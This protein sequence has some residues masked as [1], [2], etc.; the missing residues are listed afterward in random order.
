MKDNINIELSRELKTPFNEFF[1]QWIKGL[2]NIDTFAISIILP[3]KKIM[4]LSTQEIFSNTYRAKNLARYDQ[5]TQA[6]MYE[7]HEYYSWRRTGCNLL[8][9]QIHNFREHQFKMYNGTNFVRKAE[10]DEGVFYIIYSI[11]SH[12]KKPSNYVDFIANH[13]LIIQASDFFY[14][15]ML[16]HWQSFCTQFTLPSSLNTPSIQNQLNHHNDCLDSVRKKNI[17]TGFKKTDSKEKLIPHNLQLI[18]NPKPIQKSTLDIK[19]N[20]IQLIWDNKILFKE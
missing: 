19:S 7:H 13:E 9:L 11:S 6:H 18:T 14:Q 12:Q 3:N 4:Y 2:L 8:Q 10:T 20:N 17:F 15:T 16:M 1:N 5:A